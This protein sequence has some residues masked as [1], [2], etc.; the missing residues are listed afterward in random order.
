MNKGNRKGGY[1]VVLVHAIKTIVE[2]K[3]Q[4]HSFL[5]SALLRI[6]QISG[7]CPHPFH[8]QRNSPSTQ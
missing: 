3:V 7:A 1:K 4:L 2:V 5:T 8:P 6:G